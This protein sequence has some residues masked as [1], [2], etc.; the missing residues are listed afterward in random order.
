LRNG[1]HEINAKKG[2]AGKMIKNEKRIIEAI[3][4]AIGLEPLK[5]AE[6]VKKQ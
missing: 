2:E 3:L 1:L 5:P 6:P 4:T